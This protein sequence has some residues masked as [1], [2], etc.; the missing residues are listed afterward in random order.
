[1]AICHWVGAA[2]AVKDVWT[3][4]ITNTWAANDTIDIVVGTKTLTLT[5]GST[6]TTT[7]VATE[8]TA[9][10]NNTSATAPTAL[11]TGYSAN[12]GGQQFL[13]FTEFTATN[14]SAGVVVLTADT[15]GVP[16][17]VSEA[18]VTAGDG[19]AAFVHTTSATGPN[20]LS[21]AD[22]YLA[23]A[24][25][26]DN[27][28]LIFDIGDVD[29]LY[30]LDYFRTG[31]IDLHYIFTNDWTGQLGLP[32]ENASGYFE[33]RQRYF[34]VRGGSKTLRLEA[35]TEGNLN[36]GTLW[37]D[38]QD[39][40][41]CLCRFSANRNSSSGQPSVYLAGAAA[42]TFDNEFVIE[43]GFVSIEPD[44]S[45][46]SASKY[47]AFAGL[48]IGTPAS[49]ASECTVHIG[50]NTRVGASQSEL[51]INSGTVTL[52]AASSA[53]G[54][55]VTVTE[56]HGGTLY[57][58]AP[59]LA[60]HN[61]TVR[62]GASLVPVDAGAITLVNLYG[63]TLDYRQATGVGQGGATAL[64][65]YAGSTLYNPMG[66]TGEFDLFCRLEDITHQGPTNRQVNYNTA[67]S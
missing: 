6:A 4:T 7:Q 40:T 33:Y 12:F 2:T 62:S 31:N 42:A 11:G 41:A 26:V 49:A 22:N 21:N 25:P 28:T 51:T 61:I 65:V 8:L 50:R 16:F 35:G 48:S 13:E 56:M 3:L 10:I 18:V 53:G 57:L 34:Y 66:N 17:T 5:V 46:T 43:R 30:D 20:F 67:A 29:A 27:D 32:L 1:L 14:P 55:D 64:K 60:F 38:F 54:A 39:Q 23:G 58:R 59:E 9:A 24:L 44:D 19:D 52:R 63:G 37:L 45:A 47:F 36:G 15:A